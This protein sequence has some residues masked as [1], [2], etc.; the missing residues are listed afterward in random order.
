[1]IFTGIVGGHDPDWYTPNV[2]N[3]SSETAWSHL[4]DPDFSVDTYLNWSGF[5]KEMREI[6][7][8]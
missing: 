3:N 4:W 6:L 7:P 8:G 5:H 2:S 1:M